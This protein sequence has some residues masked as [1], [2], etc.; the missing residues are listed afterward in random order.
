MTLHVGSLR[1]FTSEDELRAWLNENHHYPTRVR[2]PTVLGTGEGKGFAFLDF[3]SDDDAHACMQEMNGRSLHGR[4][5][6]I[7]ESKPREPKT[8]KRT[9]KRK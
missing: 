7:M 9:A 4:C 5:L 3:N 6:T 8:T 2:M 1:Y